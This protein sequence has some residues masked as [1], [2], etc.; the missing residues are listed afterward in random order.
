MTLLVNEKIVNTKVGG[1]LLVLVG[2]QEIQLGNRNPRNIRQPSTDVGDAVFYNILNGK[3]KSYR[4]VT[5]KSE[6]WKPKAH[7]ASFVT[8]LTK[9]NFEFSRPLSFCC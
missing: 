6:F 9:F 3:N 1:L 4:K 5:Y 2:Q 8:F 7:F